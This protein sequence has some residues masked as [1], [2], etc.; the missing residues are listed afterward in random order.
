MNYLKSL[1]QI[2]VITAGLF[3][4]S[5]SFSQ[6]K[7]VNFWANRY[8]YTVPLMF[9]SGI[10]DGHVEILNHKYH[11]FKEKHPNANDKFW[12]PNIS[13]RN[14]WKNGDRSQGEKFLLSSTILVSTTDAYHMLR[15]YE[16]VSTVTAVIIPVAGKRYK[17]WVYLID[18]LVISGS[19]SLGFYLTY[20]LYYEG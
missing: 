18:F 6:K 13:W 1:L 14:K 5:E 9:T 2:V 7:D 16:H 12:N 4:T 20:E 11:K 10:V 8:K 3:F 15:T 17:F 19:K